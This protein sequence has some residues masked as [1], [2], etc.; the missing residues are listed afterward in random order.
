MTTSR[1]IILSFAAMVLFLCGLF[2]EPLMSQE[3]VRV[4][5]VVNDDIVTMR[6]VESR[7]RLALLY[8][9]LPDNRESRARVTPTVMRKLIDEK[10]QAQEASR[11]EYSVSSVDINQTIDGFLEQNQ[12]TLDKLQKLLKENNIDF[13][14]FRQEIRSELLWQG[15]LHYVRARNV[16]VGEEEVTNRLKTLKD[17]LGKPEY[18]VS[19]IFLPVG[20]MFQENEERQLAQKIID[21]LQQGA[22]FQGLA[23]QFS[24]AGGSGGNLGWL[25]EGMVDD[26]LFKEIE[27]LTIGHASSAIRTVDG[28]HI[29]YL[30]GKRKVGEGISPGP[31]VDLMSIDLTNIGSAT[32]AERRSMLEKLKA[33]T[34]PAQNCDDLIQLANKV[35]S[36]TVSIPNNIPLAGLSKNVL[37]IVEKLPNATLSDPLEIDRNL[38]RFFAVCGRHADEGGLPSR[39]DIRRQLEEERLQIEAGN[40]MRKLQ[41]AANIEIRM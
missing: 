9:N 4:A 27:R 30:M 35:P 12:L 17:N 32:Q 36:T 31:T 6:D 16:F 18:L 26:I 10:L 22:P 3:T 1:F 15:V 21:Q 8:S 33:V 25:S 39:A 37:A 13:E 2:Q 11:L 24:Q 23:L 14:S 41:R 5:A 19:E 38:R 34:A 28:Y 29:L 7:I 40:K 20:R